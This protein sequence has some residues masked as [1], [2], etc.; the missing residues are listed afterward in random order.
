MWPALSRIAAVFFATI[1]M[2]DRYEQAVACAKAAGR[3]VAVAAG[4]EEPQ[5][6][7]VIAKPLA[8]GAMS[9]TY[10]SVCIEQAMV[11]L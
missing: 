4:G 10:K 5:M 8:M 2:F 7:P 11:S 9:D 3:M 1:C 6:E